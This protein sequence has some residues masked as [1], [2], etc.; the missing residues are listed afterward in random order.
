MANYY[1]NNI[2]FYSKDRAVLQDLFTKINDVL[3]NTNTH[4]IEVVNLF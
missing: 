1:S 4:S 2:A 3:D